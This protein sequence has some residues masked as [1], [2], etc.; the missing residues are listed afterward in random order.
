M[1]SEA[2]VVLKQGKKSFKGQALLETNEI[3]FRGEKNLVVPLRSISSA[4]A[5]QGWLDVVTPQ[6]TMSLGLKDKAAAWEKKIL[7]PKS[8]VEKLGV[9]GDAAVSVIGVED[10]EFLQELGVALQGGFTRALRRD[11]D[12]IFLAVNSKSD[13]AKIGGAKT[14]LKAAGGLWIVFR[15]GKEAVMKDTEVI[16]AGKAAG[17]VDTKVVSFSETHTTLKFVIPVASRMKRSTT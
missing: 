13:L 10:E 2:L 1:G 17:L 14:H 7:H 6:G 12:L 15:K 5:R 8:R 11:S 16:R 9:K 3:R 4:R